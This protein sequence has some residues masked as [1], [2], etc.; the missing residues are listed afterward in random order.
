V[1]DNIWSRI[2]LAASRCSARLERNA[3]NYDG[4]RRWG[5][6]LHKIALLAGGTLA[7]ATAALLFGLRAAGKA[8]N[9]GFIGAGS[10]SADLNLALELALVVGLT[11]GMLLARRGRIEA[12]RI[13]QTIWTLVN[14]ALV[15]CVMVPSL[16]NAKVASPADL[17]HWSAALPGLHAAVGVLTVLSALW[18]VLQMNDILPAQWH[19]TWWKRLMRVTLVGYWLVALLGIALYFQWYVG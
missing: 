1:L 17:A 4:L 3:R 5:D 2:I 16:R 14:A 10:L 11:V 19:V 8:D 7:F 13:N 15:A 12:H 18:L 6:R 9:G